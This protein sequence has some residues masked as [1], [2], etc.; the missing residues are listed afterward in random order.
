MGGARASA[1]TSLSRRRIDG[2]VSPRARGYW[3]QLGAYV[4]ALAV[5]AGVAFAARGLGALWAAA[6]A[7]V[8]ATLVVFGFS[9]ALSNSSMYDPY[10]S[11]APP[12]LLAFWLAHGELSLRAAL[13]GALVV[14]W[15]GRLTYNFLRGFTDLTHEDW[16]YKDL[17]RKTGRFYWAVSFLGIH[18]FPT[19][20]TFLGSLSLYAIARDAGRPLGW[21][22]GVAAA[23]TLLGIGYE[24]IADEQLR[25]FV[26]GG[27]RK[28]EIMQRGLWRHSR[29]PNY[30]GEMTFWWGLYLFAAA[31]DPGA[32]WA[33]AGPIGITLLFVFVSV[34]MLDQRSLARRPGYAAHMRK[35]S[36]IVPWPR[37]SD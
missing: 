22:D 26:R 11:V 32:W 12:A 23:V 3:T 25:A 5:A 37:S 19:V 24:A 17:Q 14:L 18:F 36:A 35:V 1:S 7:D 31:A 2:A 9:V 34:P 33:I 27:P 4:V 10:W 20:L 6:A 8:A 15:G 16:R 28:G 21:L 13:V 29:H 30:F